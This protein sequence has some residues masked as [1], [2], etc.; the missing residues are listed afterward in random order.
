MVSLLLLFAALLSPTL[1]LAADPPP[2]A[3]SCSGCHP[4]HPGVETPVPRLVAR[5]PQEILAAMQ[6]FRTGARKGTVMDR[7]AKGF[8]DDEVAAIAEWYHAQH[9]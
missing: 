4:A 7:V 2:G 9:D 1:T 5:D 3:M 8:S 6:A